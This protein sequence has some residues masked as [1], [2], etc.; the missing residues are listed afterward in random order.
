[1]YRILGD[2]IFK[3]LWFSPKYSSINMAWDDES[4]KEKIQICKYIYVM[5][6]CFKDLYILYNQSFK[7]FIRH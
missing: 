4:Y 3:E 5:Q 1:M 7:I 2:F 6:S